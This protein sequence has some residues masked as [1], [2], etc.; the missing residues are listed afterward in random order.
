MES[1]ADQYDFEELRL[2]ILAGT[3][4]TRCYRDARYKYY[5]LACPCMLLC[6][7]TNRNFAWPLPIQKCY[8]DEMLDRACRENILKDIVYVLVWF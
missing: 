8:S 1:A 5:Y 2:I 6:G 7:C 3:K 4:A